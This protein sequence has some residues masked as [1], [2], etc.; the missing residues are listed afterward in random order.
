MSMKKILSICL[1]LTGLSITGCK[2]IDL[3]DPVKLPF[4]MPNNQENNSQ[5][6]KEGMTIK[7]RYLPIEWY[8]RIEY[9]EE[10]FAEFL[11]YGVCI[12]RN[13]VFIVCSSPG[14]AVIVVDMAVNSFGEKIFLLAQSYMPAQQTQLL[15]NP[16]DED[17]SPWYSLKG[18]DKLIT[19]QWTFELD[20]LKSW[21]K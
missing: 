11:R 1:L 16:M 15:I 2:S 4:N 18:R 20:T 7:D 19:P 10:S 12:L 17:I 13:I 9:K 8:T 5:I 3:E 14:H 6:N 21:E